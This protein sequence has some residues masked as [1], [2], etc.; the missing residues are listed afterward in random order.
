MM[1]RNA[2]F[3]SVESDVQVKRTRFNPSKRRFSTFNQGQ[4]VPLYVNQ[5]ILPGDTFDMTMSFKIRSRSPLAPVMD[6]AKFD[7][8]AFFVPDRLVWS[9]TKEFYGE[10]NTS[11]WAQQ[12]KYEVPHQTIGDIATYFAQQAPDFPSDMSTNMLHTLWDHFG[13]PLLN[14]NKIHSSKIPISVLPFRA[15]R[16]IY[17]DWFRDENLSNP[18]LVPT[19]DVPNLS[20][21]LLTDVDVTS[22]TDPGFVPLLRA[23]RIHDYF[24]SALPAP[25]KGDAV[26]IPLLGLAPVVTGPDFLT[27]SDGNRPE[28]RMAANTAVPEADEGNGYWLMALGN[29]EPGAKVG[30]VG[31]QM[32][33]AG[34]DSRRL[35]PANLYASLGDVS[36]VTVN[37]L[38]LAVASQRILE[39]MARGGTRFTEYL[40][41]FFGVVTPEA[42]LQIPQYLGGGTALIVNNQV[43]Q[44]SQST[45]GNPLGQTG[46]YSLTIDGKHLFTKSFDEPGTL[47]VLGCVRV[48]HTYEQR[49]DRQWTRI[50]FYDKYQ[51]PLAH[52]GEMPIYNYEL[53]YDSFEDPEDGTPDPNLEGFGYQE[54]WA[55]YRFDTNDV[56][57]EMRPSAANP[58]MRFWQYTDWYDGARPV[59]SPGWIKEGDTNVGQTLAVDSSLADQF[60]GDFFFDIDAVRP[61]PPRSTPGFM[62]H[63]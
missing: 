61:L 26:N 24:S 60:F 59:L 28:M 30:E 25:Q 29:A 33:D 40:R 51:P 19:T 32:Q 46:S 34:M 21:Y 54:A 57:G 22:G 5:Q 7:Y 10:N 14:A 12:T 58:G 49:I 52:L 39:K 42:V 63:F 35:Q 48:E 9:H 50:S 13:L 38:R 4:L 2:L 11:A 62:D 31:T 44:T 8:Y 20:E 6:N 27:Q 3:S 18:Q 36:A 37:A 43:I 15:Y 17:N 41:S 53:F 55:T 45:S 1:S 16:L 47:M 23:A 56:V